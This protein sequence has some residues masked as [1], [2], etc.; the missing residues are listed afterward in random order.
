[1]GPKPARRAADPASAHPDTICSLPGVISP[2]AR[3]R[4]PSP[5]PQPC[6]QKGGLGGGRDEGFRLVPSRAPGALFIQPTRKLLLPLA[7][8]RFSLGSLQPCAQGGRLGSHAQPFPAW[9]H[10]QVRPEQSAV[11]VHGDT[12]PAGGGQTGTRGQEAGPGT[13]VPLPKSGGPLGS[14]SRCAGQQRLAAERGGAAVRAGP[15]VSPAG[16]AGQ[17]GEQWAGLSWGGGNQRVA[18]AVSGGGQFPGTEA[19]VR[20]PSPS[21]QMYPGSETSEQRMRQMSET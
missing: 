3:A 1:M 18:S 20:L 6:A 19:V 11:F 7:S 16:G 13:S 17:G 12:S 4:N 2:I 15:A 14:P 21:L 5:S 9:W 10:R 8:R